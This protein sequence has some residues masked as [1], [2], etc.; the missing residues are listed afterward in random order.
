MVRKEIAQR[1]IA[2]RELKMRYRL[3]TVQLILI[4]SLV[5]IAFGGTLLTPLSAAL[6][7]PEITY[8]RF[9]VKQIALDKADVDFIFIVNNSNPV[10]L[11]DISMDY[12]LFLKGQSA[13]LG[14]DV[15]FAVKANSKSEIRLPVKIDYIKAFKSVEILT[16]AVVSGQKSVPFTLTSAFKI[17]VKSATFN[18]PVTARGDLPLP[19]IKVNPF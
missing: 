1:P 7:T 19:E 15:K 9:E 3:F 13:V 5:Q 16:E 17:N 12:E 4:F 8:D 6:K 10:D 11:D 14:K 18:V 2:E